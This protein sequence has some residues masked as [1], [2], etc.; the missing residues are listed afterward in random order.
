ML[1]RAITLARKYDDVISCR[2]LSLT[3]MP[4][5][6]SKKLTGDL[7][8]KEL[9]DWNQIKLWQSTWLCRKQLLSNKPDFIF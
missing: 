1:P 8:N 3:S 4:S 9:K 6:M 5:R 2:L 7:V